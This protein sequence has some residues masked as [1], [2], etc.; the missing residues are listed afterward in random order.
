MKCSLQLVAFAAACFTQRLA[1]CGGEALIV[2]VFF[3]VFFYRDAF[4]SQRTI[5]YISSTMCSAPLTCLC[6]LVLQVEQKNAF[7]TF[8]QL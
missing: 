2:F 1:M 8:L 4:Q 7:L 3:V 6:F 5:L